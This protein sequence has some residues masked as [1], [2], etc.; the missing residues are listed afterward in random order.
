MTSGETFFSRLLSLEAALRNHEERLNFLDPEVKTTNSKLD[1][2]AME[3]KA[4]YR[5]IRDLVEFDRS[6]SVFHQT[7]I[8]SKSSS[9]FYNSVR[10]QVNK[11]NYYINES[12]MEGSGTTSRSASR[13]FNDCEYFLSKT[14][15]K[16]KKNF[17]KSLSH[18][19]GRTDVIFEIKMNIKY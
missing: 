1:I 9:S 11:T 10:S 13:D 14:Y 16:L 18:R 4:N 8:S 19:K 5:E 15:Q 17:K 2:V 3:C 7:D 6:P 12:T